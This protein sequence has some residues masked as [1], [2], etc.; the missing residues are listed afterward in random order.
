MASFATDRSTIPI[1]ATPIVG[2]DLALAELTALISRPEAR[3]ITLIGPGGVGKTRLA[4]EL[5]RT[6]DRETVGDVVLVQLASVSEG[7]A[8][9]PGIARALGITLVESVSASELIVDALAT[10]RL[11]LILDNAEQIADHLAPL[12]DVL[13]HCPHLKVLVTSRVMLRLA[14]EVVFPVEPL[15]TDDTLDGALAPASELFV[16]RASAM[17]PDLPLEADDLRAIDDICR[18]L[19][20]LPLA[21]ELAAA[22]ARFL[23]P[24]ALRDRLV[25]RLSVLVGGPRDAPE[26]HQTLRATLEWSYDLLDVD[27]QALFRRLAIFRNGAPWDAVEPVCNADGALGDRTEEFLTSLIDHSLVRVSDRPATGPRIRMLNTIHGFAAELVVDRAERDELAEAHALWFAHLVID[28]PD[29]DWRTGTPELRYWTV[30][31]EPDSANLS[32]AIAWLVERGEPDAIVRLA[33]GL[34]SFWM[35]LGMYAE[36]RTWARKALPIAD[37]A[38]P[39]VQA[40][41]LFKAGAIIGLTENLDEAISITRRAI[42]LGRQTGDIRL[43]ANATNSLGVM[44]WKLGQPGEGERLQREA[45]EIV[46]ELGDDLGGGLYMTQIAEQLLEAGEFD[47]AE[48]IIREALPAIREH[49]PDAARLVQGSLVQIVLRRRDLDEAG[50]L[51]EDSIAIHVDPPHRNPVVLA[52]R[53]LDAARLAAARERPD[54][55]GQLL[56][57]ALAK[58]DASG[59]SRLDEVRR[60][61][62]IAMQDLNGSVDADLLQRESG[63]GRAMSTPAAIELALDV[64]R[65]RSNPEVNDVANPPDDVGLTERQREILQLLASGRSNAA[66]ADA[67]FI[68]ERTVTTHL[69]RIY[70][71]LGVESRAEAIAR[72][73]QLGIRPAPAA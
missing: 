34:M 27:E 3:L 17:R 11:L 1:P 55:A 58:L 21:I 53:L 72:A 4:L 70:D 67:L 24:A 13:A 41:F 32:L 68:S 38:S 56:G 44:R 14:A 25:E 5:A 10:R 47:R 22:R 45:I 51:L 16:A 42:A 50:A 19:D 18:Q 43:V 39:E 23:S 49:R 33:S 31:Y 20:G 60:A 57:A 26:R 35:E 62:E 65:M 9:F 29:A 36:L 12:A 66:I 7:D 54:D 2:R 15:S 73:H 48:S 63:F 8:V 71:R 52:E 46:K 69:T 37:L 28:K 61:V 30:R 59:L 64:S 6:I 40:T